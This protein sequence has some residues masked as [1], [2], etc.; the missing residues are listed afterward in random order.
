MAKKVA[1]PT[2]AVAVARD[3]GIEF[4]LH[5]YQHD[6]SAESFGVEAAEALGVDP[7]RV[8]K[9]LLVGVGDGLGVGIVPV[10]SQLDL[11]AVAS[12]LGVRKVQMADATVAE[13]RTGYVVGGISPLGQAHRHPTVVDAAAAA[14]QTIFVSGGRRGLE[15]ELAPADLVRLTGALVAPIAR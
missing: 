15:I 2:R 3:A 4:L 12:A 8:H 14:H 10:E 7:G 6:D 9:T 11:R 1:A 13:R 5:T